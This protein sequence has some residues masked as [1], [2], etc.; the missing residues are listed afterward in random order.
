VAAGYGVLTVN[1]N[2]ECMTLQSAKRRMD[3]PIA[4]IGAGTG[5]YVYQIPT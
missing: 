2:K 1:V 3:S 5:I 4:C